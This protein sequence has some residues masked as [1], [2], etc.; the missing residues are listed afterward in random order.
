MTHFDIL[1]PVFSCAARILLLN[2]CYN[3]SSKLLTILYTFPDFTLEHN[4]DTKFRLFI[5]ITCA[6]C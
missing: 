5:Y 6:E 2:D 1:I 4:E 3:G